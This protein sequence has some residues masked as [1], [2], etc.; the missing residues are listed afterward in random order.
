MKKSADNSVSMQNIQCNC[1]TDKSLDLTQDRKRS[2]AHFCLHFC[3]L[4][5]SLDDIWQTKVQRDRLQLTANCSSHI[6]HLLAA[7]GYISL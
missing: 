1:Q 4:R 6:R 7:A 3:I 2:S 5:G